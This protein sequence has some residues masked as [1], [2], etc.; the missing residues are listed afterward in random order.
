VPQRRPR[1]KPEYV[2]PEVHAAANAIACDVPEGAGPAEKAA[3]ANDE[4]A[5]MFAEL[6]QADYSGTTLP[7][8]LVLKGGVTSGIVYPTAICRLARDFHFKRI[9]GTSVGALAAAAAAAAEV[10][11]TR[12]GG[13]FAA[14]AGM[15]DFLST[16]NNLSNLFQPAKKLRPL[17]HVF[18]KAT[19][20]GPIASWLWALFGTAFLQFIG[21][22]AA[23]VVATVV[24]IWLLV[25]TI[26]D[27]LHWWLTVLET[28]F[29]GVLALVAV[30][31]WRTYRYATTRLPQNEFGLCSGSRAGTDAA[32]PPRSRGTPLPD[33]PLIE[34]LADQLNVYAGRDPVSQGAAAITFFDLWNVPGAAGPVDLAQR[35]VDLVMNTTNVTLGRPH[36]L[37]FDDEDQFEFYFKPAEFAEIFPQ[38]IV[39]QMRGGSPGIL[40]AP[41]GTP[42]AGQLH[43][44][45]PAHH[46]PVIVAAR[47]SMSFPLLFRAIPVHVIDRV[48]NYAGHHPVVRCLLSDG[49]LTSNMPLHFFD[50][51]IPRW[52]T[53]AI[54][55][56]NVPEE[57]ANRKTP[58][59]PRALAFMA[60]AY[61]QDHA[62]IETN[63]GG[64][65]ALVLA[66]IETMRNWND[67]VMLRVPGYKERTVQIA[68]SGVE[69]GLNLNMD[70]HTRKVLVQRGY[71]AGVTVDQR[72]AP[73]G[74]S[75]E[76]WIDLRTKRAHSFLA[77]AEGVANDY[78]AQRNY[79]YAPGPSEAEV[80]ATLPDPA[81]D[82]ENVLAFAFARASP[83][84][85]VGT[86]APKPRP[87]LRTRPRV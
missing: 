38:H 39:D 62:H 32:T 22:S 11:R 24:A 57:L 34:W 17:F 35:K 45:P 73:N 78:T 12:P 53:F 48:P 21:A 44:F 28:L 29:I 2:S 56:R 10:G 71:F 41:A 50:G 72:F 61:A 25:R 43:R 49:G 1:S 23:V 8:D 55:L 85:P 33:P 65:V 68:L 4:L 64:I 5:R 37:P 15:A 58:P 60:N 7:C 40:P 16:G 54:D 36:R 84:L 30:L 87:E 51:P 69:G 83:A 13:G 82:F 27:P 75:N 67:A 46:L 79:G 59:L 52:P 81:P 42:V 80:V 14:F 18:V 66:I 76:H 47:M 74:Q 63:A 9:G 19:S 6:R 70:E 31:S 3:A 20:G 77:M 26:S 86:D